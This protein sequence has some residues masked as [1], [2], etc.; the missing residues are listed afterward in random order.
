MEGISMKSKHQ[1]FITFLNTLNHGDVPVTL[2]Q[3]P[4]LPVLIRIGAERCIAVA[5][6]LSDL[7]A[8]EVGL[9]VGLVS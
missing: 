1:L 3:S 8:N 6:I 5:T 9:L 7:F 4:L 2:V